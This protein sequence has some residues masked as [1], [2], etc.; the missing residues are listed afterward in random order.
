M[1]SGCNSWRVRVLG[2][3]AVVDNGTV[4]RAPK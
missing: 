2:I 3:E 1:W 4:A